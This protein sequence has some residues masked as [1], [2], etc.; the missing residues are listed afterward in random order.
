MRSRLLLAIGS[1]ILVSACSGSLSSTPP[2]LAGSSSSFSLA[3]SEIDLT[4]GVP[5]DTFNAQGDTVGVS[6]TPYAPAACS[7]STGSIVVSGQ[8]VA[9]VDVAG[10][11]LLF[12]V[13]AVGATPPSS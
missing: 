9:Q 13:A 11:P 1:A 6:Y 12:V 8:G 5:W 7:T 4:P 2:S 10:S 3:P